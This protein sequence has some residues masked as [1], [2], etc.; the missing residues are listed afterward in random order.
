MKR[1]SAIGAQR[2]ERPVDYVDG[3]SVEMQKVRVW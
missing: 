3:E 2:A 1:R